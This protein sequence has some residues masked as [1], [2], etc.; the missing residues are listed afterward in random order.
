MP[1]SGGVGVVQ[2][3][4]WPRSAHG[5]DS[6]GGLSCAQAAVAPSSVTHAAPP[7]TMKAV[8]HHGGQRSRRP[9]CPFAA[10]A[11][12]EQGAGVREGF[13]VGCRQLPKLCGG[14]RLCQV[15]R[16][17][18]DLAVRRGLLAVPRRI[19]DLRASAGW[20]RWRSRARAADP[21]E[22]GEVLGVGVGKGVQ[23]L[24]GGGDL[25]VT[26]P[27]HHRLEVGPSGEQ[28]GRMSVAQVVDAYVEVHPRGGDGGSPDPGAEGVPR[29]WGAVAGREQQVTRPE[30][31][32]GDPVGELVDEVG[33]GYPWFGVRCPWGRAW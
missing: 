19:P 11:A 32:V 8:A 12:L 6:G 17:R 24:L 28:P 31:A 1:V 22:C 3:G 5:G 9:W 18:H 26:H 27:V 23:V 10:A 14:L 30:P 25:C 20:L 29:K 16:R 13:I 4:R 7:R 33:W 2:P 15:R 21:V